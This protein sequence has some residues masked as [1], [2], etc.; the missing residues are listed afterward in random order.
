[1]R[2]QKRTSRAR[3]LIDNYDDRF[4]VQRKT[5][6]IFGKAFETVKSPGDTDVEFDAKLMN[7]L[8]IIP[9]ELNHVFFSSSKIMIDA[10]TPS[11]F[12]FNRRY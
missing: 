11:E 12:P 9:M 7:D 3:N 5:I 4:A 8:E 1:M 6:N 10:L 2:R